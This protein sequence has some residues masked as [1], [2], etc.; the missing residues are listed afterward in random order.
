[1]KHVNE[2]KRYRET[3]PNTYLIQF[4]KPGISTA[5]VLS[6]VRLQGKH[7]HLC[8]NL[9]DCDCYR[10]PAVCAMNAKL[11]ILS[12]KTKTQNY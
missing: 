7:L 3:K 8:Y 4:L 1:M 11:M 5:T 12:P 10:A 6:Q 2:L 9:C